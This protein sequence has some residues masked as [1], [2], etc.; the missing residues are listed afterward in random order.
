[1]KVTR[2]KKTDVMELTSEQHQAE[3]KALEATKAKMTISFAA[4]KAE[5]KLAKGKKLP[6]RV[7][8][9]EVLI[10]E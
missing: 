3:V 2:L 5:E 10:L 7:K 6:L 8:T 4:N 1:M 9:V